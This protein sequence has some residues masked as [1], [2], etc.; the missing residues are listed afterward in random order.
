LYSNVENAESKNWYKYGLSGIGVN[1]TE[2]AEDRGSL[3]D[4]Y[5]NGSKRWDISFNVKP[6]PTISCLSSRYLLLNFAILS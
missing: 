5:V 6:L 2:K 4:F 1:K 3:T